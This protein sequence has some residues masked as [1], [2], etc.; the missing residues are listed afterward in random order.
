MRRQRILTTLLERD[1]YGEVDEMRVSATIY[2]L[3]PQGETEQKRTMLHFD[4]ITSDIVL[5][6]EYVGFSHMF[7]G[8]ETNVVIPA[9]SF[10]YLTYYAQDINGQVIS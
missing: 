2:I 10:L 9:D 7:Y 5:N 1:W 8:R 3:S 6:D 4:D